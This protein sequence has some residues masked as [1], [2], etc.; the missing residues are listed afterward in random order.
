MS[1]KDAKGDTPRNALVTGASSGIGAAFVR[2]LARDG[3]GV[4]AVARRRERLEALAQEIRDGAGI[5]VEVLAADLTDPAGLHAVETRIRTAGRLE[6]LVNN[7]GFSGYMP[8]V[9]L[10]PDRAETLLRL[11]IVAP[12]RLT[13]A[14]LPGMIARGGTVINVSSLLAFSAPVAG[15]PLPKR[16]TYA[17]AK[18][19][20]NAFTML[21]HNELQGTGVRLQALCPGVVETEFHS[22]AE[23]AG[24]ASAG[25]RAAKPEEI[26]KA[27]LAG[28]RLGELIC[29]PTLED[30]SLI[31]R[32]EDSARAI[33]QSGRG[34]FAQR[35]A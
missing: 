1:A 17:A 27:S 32:H 4:I 3:Y 23:R 22:D 11:Q 14:A 20:L 18:A 9:E 13:R 12:T 2:R 30:A 5:G 31:A 6:M 35:Y 33:L 34:A 10:D 8:F 21:L 26:V 19:Y 29:V 28:L 24:L 15:G 16:V 25:V 7:A